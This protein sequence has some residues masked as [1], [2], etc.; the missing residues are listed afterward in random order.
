MLRTRDFAV[1]AGA[2]VV[3]L[4][5]IMVTVATDALSGAGGQVAS[6]VN[7]ADS[8][9]VSGAETATPSR[10][11]QANADRLKGKIAAGEGDVAAGEPIFTSVDTVVATDMPIITDQTPVASVQIGHTLDGQPL[12]SDGLWRFVWFTANDQIGTAQNGRPIYGA[13]PNEVLVD[14]CGGYDDGTGYKLYLSVG[15]NIDLAC[16]GA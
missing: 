8:A 2:L 3:L 12:M 16:F 6:V 4:A 11:R 7:F 14:S 10:D 15:G 13:H 1:F 5:M 9:T